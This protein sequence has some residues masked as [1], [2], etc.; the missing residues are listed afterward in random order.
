[1]HTFFTKLTTV[2]TIDV[3]VSRSDT[4]VEGNYGHGSVFISAIRM[5]EAAKHGSYKHTLLSLLETG[6]S[7]MRLTKLRQLVYIK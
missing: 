2:I 1:M 5:K 3:T 4:R 6:L 7:L